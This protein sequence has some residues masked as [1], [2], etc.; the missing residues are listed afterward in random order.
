MNYLKPLKLLFIINPRSGNNNTDRKI[1]IEEYFQNSSHV[2]DWL[3]LEGH[4]TP[5][6]LKQH[7]SRFQPDRVVAVGGDGTIRLAAECLLHSSIPL[8]IIPAGSANGLAKELNI[9]A[10]IIKALDIIMDATIKTIHITKINDQVCVHLSDL[11]FNAFVIKKFETIAHRGM[12]G[13][14]KAAWKVLWEQSHMRV[15]MTIDGKKI[16][17]RAAMIVIA[18]ATRYGSGACINP[19]GK[20]DDDVFEVVAVKKVS[21]PEIFK[22]MVTH[23]PFDTSKTELFQVKSLA[24]QSPRKVHFQVDGE[25]LGKVNVVEASL[26]PASLQIIVPKL[27]T[28]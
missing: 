27:E 23:T 25:Y 24:I 21:F 22:M 12:F 15:S 3:F 14:I 20:L 28:A 2:L 6:I 8:G 4:I 19:A 18:N 9:P 1:L 11:G 10:D 26:L 16:Q 17:L 7:L 5:E 13:Y